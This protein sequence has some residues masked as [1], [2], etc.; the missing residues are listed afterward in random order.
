MQ[1]LHSS[2]FFLLSEE[3]SS[4]FLLS[5]ELS[6][7]IFFLLAHPDRK[8]KSGETKPAQCITL[9]DTAPTT[10]IAQPRNTMPFR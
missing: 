4:F 6:N 9:C 3:L 1:A 2:S 10:A 7:I 8:T 5:E